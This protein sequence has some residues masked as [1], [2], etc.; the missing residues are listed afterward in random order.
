MT[1]IKFP[2]ALVNELPVFI[3]E[4]EGGDAYCLDSRRC[5]QKLAAKN[6]GKVRRHHFSHLSGS[7]P[8][9]GQ[10]HWATQHL[11]K[12]AFDEARKSGVPYEIHWRC[13][14]CN[15][16]QALDLVR[17]AS[18]C[19]IEWTGLGGA[20]ADL[21]F[22]DDSGECVAV[23]EVVDTS[24]LRPTTNE[25]YLAAKI[26]VYKTYPLEETLADYREAI[27]ADELAGALEDDVGHCAECQGKAKFKRTYAAAVEAILT[28]GIPL[29]RA[30]RLKSDRG[31]HPQ[32]YPYPDRWW[33]VRPVDVREVIEDSGFE[34]L[35]ITG[36]SEWVVSKQVLDRIIVL[37]APHPGTLQ[38]DAYLSVTKSDSLL[39]IASALD[40]FLTWVQSDWKLHVG[41]PPFGLSEPES[42]ETPQELEPTPSEPRNL[43][44]GARQLELEVPEEVTQPSPEP[45]RA[46]RPNRLT[47]M[48]MLFLLFASGGR[49]GGRRKRSRR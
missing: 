30:F 4:Y 21:A 41:E 6:R 48:E 24:D 7:C 27:A 8:G 45:R 46:S 39:S 3:D 2:V 1:D 10:L 29:S 15:A 19:V 18:E 9:M 16:R 42:E 14:S 49:G 5:G 32:G 47:P 44:E 35:S 31:H 25:I 38:I 22:L 37:H 28:D 26:P 11:V 20:R 23:V 40:W 17:M 36:S 43:D 33:D 13:E 12:Q 34:R